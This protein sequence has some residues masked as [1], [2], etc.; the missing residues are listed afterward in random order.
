MLRSLISVICLFVIEGD[1]GVCGVVRLLSFYCGIS[2]NKI[3]HCGI[4]V[5]SN[6]AVCVVGFFKPPVFGET[7]LFA[8]LR[9][10]LRSN[11][12]CPVDICTSA[13]NRERFFF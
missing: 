5:I 7:K 2:V 12:Y 11:I 9:F 6:P 1:I 10:Q 13:A 3:P 4:A 8:V